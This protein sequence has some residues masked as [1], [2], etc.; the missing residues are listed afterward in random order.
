MSWRGIVI[1]QLVFV[2]ACGEP[3]D[4]PAGPNRLDVDPTTMVRIE[5]VTFSMGQPPTTPGP[6]GQAWKENEFFAH[7]VTLS[8]YLIDRDEVTV[9][10][11]ADFLSR[12]GGA[13][14]H[15]PLQPV[16]REGRSYTPLPDTAQRPITYVSFYDAA[17]FCAWAGKRLPTEAEWELAA[18]GPTG[19]P[20]PWGEDEPTC[21]HANFFTGNASC[22][23]TPVEVGSHSPLGDS[24]KGL[25]DM[26]GN[27]AEWVADFYDAYPTSSVVD[28][29]GPASG[30]YRVIRGGGLLDPSVALRTQGRFAGRP[31]TRSISVG[32]RCAVTP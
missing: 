24:A 10:A 16:E 22:K 25:H 2:A 19:T 6:Y 17:T 29:T 4:E 7:Q 18:R 9:A 23:S 5:G 21:A 27:V 12:A 32:F 31:N 8:A 13:V 30:T 14:H 28:P 26:A 3:L 11:Y 20:Y 1:A 15:H